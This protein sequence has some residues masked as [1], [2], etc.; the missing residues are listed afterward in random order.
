VTATWG[1]PLALAEDVV[2]VWSVPLDAP[3]TLIDHIASLSADERGRAGRIVDARHRRRFLAAH[4]AVRTILA[5]YLGRSPAAV[6][7]AVGDHGKPQLADGAAAFNLA[8]DG[9][10]ALVAVACGREVG[11]D[12]ESVDAALPVDEVARVCLSGRERGW[13]DAKEPI[14]RPRAFAALWVAKEAYL[15]ARGL[16]LTLAPSHVEVRDADTAPAVEGEPRI[17][18]TTLSVGADRA[19]ALAVQGEAVPF[20]RFS[21]AW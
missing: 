10:L 5:S 2:H 17:A 19:A 7:V 21:Y 11:I 6:E 16:G 20:A 8:H 9:D 12:V 14:D 13:L 4:V 15:K 18:L 3:V 1:A